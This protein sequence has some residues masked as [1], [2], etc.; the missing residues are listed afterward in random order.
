[1]NLFQYPRKSPACAGQSL[2]PQKTL[3]L[4]LL[5][6]GLATA[7]AQTNVIYNFDQ[8]GELE[9]NFKPLGDNKF[10]E[11]DGVGFKE[12]GG[13][14]VSSS[15]QEGVRICTKPVDNTYDG[16][17]YEI[18][19]VFQYQIDGKKPVNLGNPLYIGLATQPE[20]EISLAN[21]CAGDFLFAMLQRVENSDQ[22]C[23]VAFA[24]RNS[25]G[26]WWGDK[27]AVFELQDQE[28]YRL[29]LA[30]RFQGKQ[31]NCD[32][33][34][35]KLLPDGKPGE[36]ISFGSKS[37][38]NPALLTSSAYAFFGSQMMAPQRGV[39]SMDNFSISSEPPAAEQ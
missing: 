6:A 19:I 28:W 36:R 10:K 34:V 11:G 18:S 4:V 22:S 24:A 12:S 33:G 39:R 2:A 7:P 35:H 37:V 15:I 9:E 27:T 1:M 5:A 23:V 21:E 20:G 3:L 31:I 29:Y 32:Y 13:V 25:A 14:V 17:K 26:G 8:P 30:Y 16:A 38:T